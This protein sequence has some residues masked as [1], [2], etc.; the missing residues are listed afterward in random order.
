MWFAGFTDSEEGYIAAVMYLAGRDWGRREQ[1]QK[2]LSITYLQTGRTG[3]LDEL[4]TRPFYLLQQKQNTKLCIIVQAMKHETE[5]KPSKLSYHSMKQPPMQE[6]RCFY[7]GCLM[8]TDYRVL[9][10]L[11]VY[12]VGC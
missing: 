5:S 2:V 8:N 6:R 3:D 11:C 4:I 9:K 12:P 7:Y 10:T 1:K